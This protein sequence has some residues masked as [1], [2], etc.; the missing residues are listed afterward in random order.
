MKFL[1]THNQSK[2]SRY[3]TVA[4][5]LLLCISFSGLTGCYGGF[6][7]TKAVY[8]LNDEV[9]ENMYV[10]TIIFWALNILPVYPVALFTDAFVFNIIE[11]YT[12]KELRIGDKERRQRSQV[13]FEAAQN[14]PILNVTVKND[15][16]IVDRARLVKIND[17][18]IEV[19]DNDNRLNAFIIKSED[20]SLTITDTRGLPLSQ[21][22]ANDIR[23][24]ALKRQ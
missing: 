10:T 15:G 22:S 6:P 13:D 1:S 20:G 14:S 2:L 18:I 23:Q 21:I 16:V 5:V 24:M 11:F 12:G 4:V 8:R 19:Y 3:L 17:A 9:S 7:L